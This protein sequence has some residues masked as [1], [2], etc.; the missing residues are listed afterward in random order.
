[1][2]LNN[3]F[4]VAPLDSNINGLTRDIYNFVLEKQYDNFTS[5]FEMMKDIRNDFS[6]LI[7]DKN[8]VYIKLKEVNYFKRGVFIAEETVDISDFKNTLFKFI[9]TLENYLKDNNEIIN[10]NSSIKVT[11]NYNDRF[12][13]VGM[14]KLNIKPTGRGYGLLFR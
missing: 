5:E 4:I 8:E 10:E 9:L 13:K 2:R 7:N 6:S 1:M 14:N 3:F 12:Q 11:Y